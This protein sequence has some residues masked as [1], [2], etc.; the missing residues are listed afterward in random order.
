[1]RG[2]FLII[3]KFWEISNYL[4]SKKREKKIFLGVTMLSETEVRKK[5]KKKSLVLKESD[6]KKRT[7]VK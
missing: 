7:K 5:K 1:M 2:Y 6:V 4:V 3:E